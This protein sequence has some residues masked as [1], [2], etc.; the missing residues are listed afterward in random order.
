MTQVTGSEYLLDLEVP[1]SE[2]E[3]LQSGGILS[4]IWHNEKKLVEMVEGKG[5]GSKV[6]Y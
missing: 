5:G 3:I 2:K 6:M 1:E 4:K